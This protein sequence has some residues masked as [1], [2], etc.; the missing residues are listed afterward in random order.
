MMMIMMM[1]TIMKKVMMVT[2]VVLL[3]V[4]LDDGGG[5]DVVSNIVMCFSSLRSLSPA[6]HH[7]WFL[8]IPFTITL[9]TTTIIIIIIIIIIITI[10]ITNS[11]PLLPPHHNK[12]T[13][14]L[15]EYSLTP[16]LGS[17]CG[18]VVRGWKRGTAENAMEATRARV[19][20]GERP[21]IPLD[22]D[23]RGV[24]A[25]ALWS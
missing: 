19:A 3:V 8:P 23:E 10:I 22:D 24:A 15:V 11:I 13:W 25:P 5:V 17:A 2:V 12:L 21:P 20:R 7:T 14:S 1:M 4:M 6:H 18:T 9:T 16:I